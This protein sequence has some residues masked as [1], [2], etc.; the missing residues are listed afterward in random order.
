MMLIFL[1][2]GGTMLQP[3]RAQDGLPP[4]PGQPR[5]ICGEIVSQI[6]FKIYGS[7][8]TDVAGMRE[9]TDVRHKRTF[10]IAPQER[11]NICS[12]GPFFEGQRVELTLKT[13]FPVFSCRTK[14]DRE[15]RLSATP[16]KEGGYTYTA[17]CF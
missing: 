11:L 1:L 10:S 8:M 5:Q 12:S 13:M 3:A 4:L 17:T 14:I 7:V 6:P 2:Q 16:N 15:I 9:G